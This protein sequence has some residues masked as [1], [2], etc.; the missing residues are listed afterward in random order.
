MTKIFAIMLFTLVFT[1]GQT[2]AE[3]LQTNVKYISKSAVYVDAGRINGIEVGDRGTVI[4]GIEIIAHMEVIFV[5]DNSASC[6]IVES[7]TP[8]KVGDQV[9]M[10]VEKPVI[11][12]DTTSSNTPKSVITPRVKTD[13]EL[14]ARTRKELTNQFSGRLGLQYY[15]QDNLDEFDNDFIQPSYFLRFRIEN[16]YG[17]YHS[18]S[19]R[20]KGRKN[21]RDSN[22]HDI[23]SSSWN[24]RTYE[25]SIMFDNPNSNFSYNAGRIIPSQVSGLGLMDGISFEYK[26]H[27]KYQIGIFG[28]TEPD[29]E[30]SNYSSEEVKSGIFL[31]FDN[32][33]L[34]GSR[35]RTTGALLGVYKAGEIDREFV[36]I[37]NSYSYKSKTSFYQSGEININRDWRRDKSNN[38]LEISNFQTSLRWSPVRA[39]SLNLG[40]N[41]LRNVRNADNRTVADSLFDDA[42]R[43]GFRAGCIFRLPDNIRFS[44]NGNVRSRSSDNSST[45]ATSSNLS[46]TDRRISRI[47]FNGRGSYFSNKYSEGL[48]FSFSANRNITSDLGAGIEVGV[49]DYTLISSSTTLRNNWLKLD[50]DYR[51]SR[52]L[53]LF[54]FFEASRGD[55]V[56][57]NRWMVDAGYRFR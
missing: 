26:L 22:L 57:T 50:A 27:E 28:G 37:R 51:I 5:A 21:I 12:L 46:Y 3:E 4:R 17:S 53:Y 40:Y 48:Q 34:Q 41:N 9:T 56:K 8:L 14:I 33:N 39:F 32:R 35:I 52:S 16:I 38:T 25:L 55:G 43:Q 18:L 2:F 1:S 11:S 13:T 24:N 44:I 42:L 45:Y 36:Y 31:T 6:R 23:S 30:T 15:S 47:R 49:R 29:Y 54:T 20:M 19:L 7:K 10:I